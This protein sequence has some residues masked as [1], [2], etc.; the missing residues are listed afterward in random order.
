M[1]KITGSVGLLL[2]VARLVGCDHGTKPLRMG[3]N[4]EPHGSTL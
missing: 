4:W 1:R 2:L 3:D